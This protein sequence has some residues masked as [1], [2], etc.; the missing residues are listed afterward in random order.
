MS[1]ATILRTARL[2]KGL[3]QRALA[4]ECNVSQPAIARVESAVEQATLER[5]ESWLRPL[6]SRITLVPFRTRTVW[7]AVEVIRDELAHD[8]FRHAIREVVQLADDL[9]SADPATRVALCI[10]PP[11]TTGD[12][13]FDALVAGITDEILS[14]DALP[15]PTW[16][17]DL[18]WY[19]QEPWDVEDVP[20]LQQEARDATPPNIAQHGVF[21]DRSFFE[22]A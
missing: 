1:A 8:G 20:A 17:S 2:N 9:R 12:Q 21:L 3:S 7:E 15:R 5:L 11:S 6:G 16:I 4:K 13:R 14:W 22:R 10:N 18:R 19:L